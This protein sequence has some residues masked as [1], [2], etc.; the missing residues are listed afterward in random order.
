MQSNLK[1]AVVIEDDPISA[2]LL[3]ELLENFGFTVRPFCQGAPALSYLILQE[4]DLIVTD[5]FLPDL[6][7][8]DLIRALHQRKST[9]VIAISGQRDTEFISIRK[10][11][12]HAGAIAFFGKPCDPRLLRN[13]LQGAGLVGG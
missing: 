6:D 12:L 2:K 7:G 10:E 1:S 5:I 9:P 8:I 4:V 11:A 13:C 3:A